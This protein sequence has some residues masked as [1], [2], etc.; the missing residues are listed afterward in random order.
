MPC[1]TF[2]GEKILISIH[3]SIRQ[4]VGSNDDYDDGRHNNNNNRIIM[5][6]RIFLCE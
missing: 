1:Y 6:P 2:K 5:N 3:K 4:K